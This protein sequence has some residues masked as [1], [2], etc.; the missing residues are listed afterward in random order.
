MGG[1]GRESERAWV[2][3]FSRFASGR[4]LAAIGV[5]VLGGC[6]TKL[7]SFQV[8]PQTPEY[9]LKSPD[10]R[11]TPFPDILHAYNGFVRGG[12]SVDLR[13]LMKMHIENAYYQPGSSRRGL[14]G[15]LGT[16]K[17]AYDVSQNGLRLLSVESMKN[18]PQ[19]D[20]PVEK[21]IPEDQ[22]HFRQ[23]RFYFEI[24]FARS[25]NSRGSVL[26]GADS[27]GELNE[28]SARLREPESVCGTGAR[29]CAVFPEAC[30]VAIYMTVVVNGKKQE[31]VWGSSVASVLEKPR[32]FTMKRLYNGHL[33]P[34]RMAAGDERVL[35]MQLLPGD[36]IKYR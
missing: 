1:V 27:V 31:A 5:L 20:P 32:P 22:M 34:V 25:N 2:R 11:E 36:E 4:W 17:A 18:R 23:Y 9:L 19:A 35:A 13:P 14:D 28:L 16:E 33:L 8:V 30:S 21:L 26:L 7:H 6:S 15:F 29:H 12:E 3:E 24:I 10:A